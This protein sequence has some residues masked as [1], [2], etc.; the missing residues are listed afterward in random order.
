MAKPFVSKAQMDRCKRLVEEGAMSQS[1]YDE[2][3]AP[4][5]I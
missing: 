2:S 1:V 4:G 3:L 5:L